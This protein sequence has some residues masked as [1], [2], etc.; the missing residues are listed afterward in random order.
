MARQE[1]SIVEE[2]RR[3]AYRALIDALAGCSKTVLLVAREQLTL[4]AEAEQVFRQLLPFRQRQVRTTQWPGTELI[5]HFALV[6]YYPVSLEVTEI[7]KTAVEGLYEWTQ[8]K[9]PEDICL[10]G[11]DDEPT[12]TTI[13]HEKDAWVSLSPE[14]MERVRQEV[15]GRFFEEPR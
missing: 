7:V 9:C 11:H 8:P 6:N 5:G 13:S 4:S 1:C 12:L 15:G 10:L 14:A 3:E 2:P